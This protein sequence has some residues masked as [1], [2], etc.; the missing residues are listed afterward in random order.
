MERIIPCEK[1]AEFKFCKL[2]SAGT[3]VPLVHPFFKLEYEKL[4]ATNEIHKDLESCRYFSDSLKIL[5][6]EIRFHFYEN[7]IYFETLDIRKI[8]FQMHDYRNGRP[9]EGFREIL[10]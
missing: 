10:G 7:G 8:I 9:K 4:D 2:D 6:L 3:C 5:A 1:L